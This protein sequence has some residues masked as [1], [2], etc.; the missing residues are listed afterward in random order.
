MPL[1]I[2]RLIAEL[3]TP[4]SLIALA[5]AIPEF[6][7]TSADEIRQRFK[8]YLSLFMERTRISDFQ[9]CMDHTGAAII[10][11]IASCVLTENALLSLAYQSVNP[12]QLDILMPYSEHRSTEQWRQFLISVGYEHIPRLGKPWK[13]GE[14]ISKFIDQ[15]SV[16]FQMSSLLD[17]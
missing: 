9:L 15:G 1:E 13:S 3:L 16:S 10:G 6:S 4:Q 12:L 11:G 17:C 5:E 8:D 7:P 14:T 2:W